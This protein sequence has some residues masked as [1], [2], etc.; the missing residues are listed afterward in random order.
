MLRGGDRRLHVRQTLR[1]DNA[2]R[3]QMRGDE[4]RGKFDELADSRSPFFRG[5]GLLLHRDMAGEDAWMPTVLTLGD[6]HPEP[7]GVMPSADN[8]PMFGVNDFDEAYYA[9]SPIVRE[10]LQE[11]QRDRAEWLADYLDDDRRGF[12]ASE[13]IVPV[14]RRVDEMQALVERYAEDAGEL[15]KRAGALRVKDVAR[16]KGSGTA[17]L[18]LPRYFVL[19]EGPEGDGTDDLILEMKRARRSAL[20]GLAPPSQYQQTGEA[21][22]VV[23]AQAVH[24]VGGDQLYGHVAIDGLS[25]LVRERSPFEEEIDLGDLSSSDWKRYAAA[26]RRWRTRTRCRTT[27][28]PSRPTSSAGSS[29]RSGPSAVSCSSRTPCASPKTRRRG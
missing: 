29:P 11:A 7:F 16:K 4:A 17:S 12:V 2:R 22:R 20:D 13:E 21:D 14:T 15:P 3:I 1:E 5:T 8:T 6:V 24:L 9:P 28:G 19:V 23:R 27:Q 26:G 10:L 18:G 25:F